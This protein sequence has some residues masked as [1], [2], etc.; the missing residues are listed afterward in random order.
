MSAGHSHPHHHHQ[1]AGDIGTA[2][3][4]NLA[5][6]LVEFVGGWLT[7]STAILADAVHDLGDSFAFGQAWYFEKLSLSGSSERYSYGYRRFSLVGALISALILFGGS[8]FVLLQAIPK[9]FAPGTP[10]AG[11]MALLAV[12]GVSVNF[13]AMLRLRKTGG[14][15]ARVVT[16]HLLEDVLGWVAVLVVAVVLLFWDIPVLD[17]ILAIAITLFILYGALKN[18]RSM[19]PVFLQAVPDG[20]SLQAVV[21]EAE[22]LDG[23][24]GVHNAHIWSLDGTH[25]V[26]TAHLQVD[27][28]LDACAYIEL[29]KRIA[30]LV[31]SHGIEHSTVEIEYPGEVCRITDNEEETP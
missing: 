10:D 1:A 11:G 20:I 26:F 7:G 22:A 13:L 28:E 12:A 21:R 4:L 5:F 15:N 25:R 31:Q 16:L 24:R 30:G 29:K 14:M 9:I 23:V 17:P 18:L 8:I 6:T 19:V 2:F 27:P 3:F